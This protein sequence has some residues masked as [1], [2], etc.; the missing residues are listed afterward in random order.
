MVRGVLINEGVGVSIKNYIKNK[1][2]ALKSTELVNTT[3]KSQY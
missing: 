3:L 2:R 1:K